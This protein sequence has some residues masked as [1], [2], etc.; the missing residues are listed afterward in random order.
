MG[1]HIVISAAQ[2]SGYKLTRTEVTSPAPSVTFPHPEQTS[3]FRQLH[4]Q[5]ACWLTPR[6]DHSRPSLHLQQPVKPGHT[7]G[8][9]HPRQRTVSGPTTRS[10]HFRLS[11]HFPLTAEVRTN[12]GRTAPSG[13]PSTGHAQCCPLLPSLP[14]PA[15]LNSSLLN[16]THL[17]RHDK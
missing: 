12:F 4:Q 6:S 16:K 3:D 13:P 10:G 2:S 14:L 17:S 11:R 15:D 1:S 9:C 5:T 8:V 7:S